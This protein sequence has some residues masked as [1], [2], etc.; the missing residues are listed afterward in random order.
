MKR[1]LSHKGCERGHAGCAT[2]VTECAT[3]ADIGKNGLQAVDGDSA[4][5]SSG[6]THMTP[7]RSSGSCQ[8]FLAAP[9]K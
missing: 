3:G 1:S 4:S 5:P 2:G 6:Q 9:K 7:V 8:P